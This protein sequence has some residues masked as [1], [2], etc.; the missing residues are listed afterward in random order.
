VLQLDVRE[1]GPLGELVGLGGWSLGAGELGA[2]TGSALAEND[3]CAVFRAHRAQTPELARNP[4]Q[5][6]HVGWAVLRRAMWTFFEDRRFHA[7]G[8]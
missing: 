3:A 8:Q 7:T 4:A 6:G 2:A 5:L 1:L